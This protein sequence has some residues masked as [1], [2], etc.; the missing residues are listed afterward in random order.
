VLAAIAALALSGCGD[1]AGDRL[2]LTT[3]Q[4][5]ST[6]RPLPE[7]ARADR[8]AERAARV[9]LTARDA[10]RLRPVLRGWGETLRRGRGGGAARYFALPVIVAE[11]SVLVLDTAAQVRAFNAGLPCGARL[12]SAKEDGRFVVGT[13]VW[14]RRPHHACPARGRR[15]RLAF[16]FALGDRKIAEWREVPKGA[17]SPGP[18]R[19]ETAPDPP[20]PNV[21]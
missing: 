10:R 9:R 13:F 21:S 18:A 1:D 14:T 17:S 3:P 15:V 4:E 5:R 19:P 11:Q 6:A 2:A 20:L 8:A 7:V 16:A 12:L